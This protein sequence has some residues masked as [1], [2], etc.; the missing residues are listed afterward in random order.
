MCTMFD[1]EFPMSICWQE[2]IG[3]RHLVM[4]NLKRSISA[5]CNNNKMVKIRITANPDHLR[6]HFP[7]PL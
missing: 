7:Y 4:Q 6:L 2:R 3:K 5:L 1:T